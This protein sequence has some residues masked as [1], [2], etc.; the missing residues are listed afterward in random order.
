MH[1][2]GHKLIQ[3]RITISALIHN[4]IQACLFFSGLL[5]DGLALHCIDLWGLSAGPEVDRL[6]RL[7]IVRAM[8]LVRRTSKG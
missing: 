7:F 1:K 3:N 8:P 6:Y 2:G 5:N 4:R